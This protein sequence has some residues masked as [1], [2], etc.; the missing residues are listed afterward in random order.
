MG[1]L[2]GGSLWIQPTSIRR[3]PR[4]LTI[5]ITGALHTIP[6]DSLEVLLHLPLFALPAQK[7]AANS[8]ARLKIMS[9]F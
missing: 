3:V 4:Q 5:A 7:L 2:F 8:A 6:S 1:Q 9:F